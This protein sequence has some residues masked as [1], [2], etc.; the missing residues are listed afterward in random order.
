LARR[1]R[2]GAPLTLARAGQPRTD[3]PLSHVS[4]RLAD[5][6]DP[7]P[8]AFALPTIGWPS[9]L[10]QIAGT[11]AGRIKPR[12]QAPAPNREHS[13]RSS[14][15]VSLPA[16]SLFSRPAAPLQSIS[17]PLIKSSV[18][19]SLPRLLSTRPRSDN[20]RR[21]R[22]PRPPVGEA[23]ARTETD[24]SAHEHAL[25]TCR[26]AHPH[27]SHPPALKQ[28]SSLWSF[29]SLWPAACL[30][31]LDRGPPQDRP[32]RPRSAPSTPE[33]T[34]ALRSSSSHPAR[35]SMPFNSTASSQTLATPA[36]LHGVTVSCTAALQSP[37]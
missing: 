34:T 15:P 31:P 35:S 8:D 24:H 3:P 25:V 6:H 37:G 29:V 18:A 2:T 36:Q 17:S 26:S 14:R 27:R 30:S 21:H 32:D 19:G 13:P 11:S 4:R 33:P 1:P 5:D 20:R 16:R 7:R 22:R 23:V 12:R 10:A 28:P 9:S